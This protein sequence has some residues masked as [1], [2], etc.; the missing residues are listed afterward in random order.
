MTSND[1][2]VSIVTF[3]NT[4]IMNSMQKFT[5][6]V[7][8]REN[9][10]GKKG[11]KHGYEKTCGQ[12]WIRETQKLLMLYVSQSLKISPNLLWSRSTEILFKL[13]CT[14]L[15]YLLHILLGKSC[16]STALFESFCHTVYYKWLY[17]SFIYD[18]RILI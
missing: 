8:E 9:E 5:G 12:R 16:N 1:L 6:F 4:V 10:G 15:S 2:S 18:K 3:F 7:K 13:K 11:E 17:P 14:I